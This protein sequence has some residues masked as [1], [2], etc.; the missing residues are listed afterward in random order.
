MKL[1]ISWSGDDSRELASVLRDWIP[2]VIQAAQ[3][4]FSPNDVDKG[5]RWSS[6]IAREL[7]ESD[8]GI[9][10]ITRNNL[11]KPWLM[12]EAGALSK[13]VEKSNL[14]PILFGVDDSDLSGPLTHFQA[15]RFKKSEIRAL[16]EVINDKCGEAKLAD[17]VLNDVFD[18][19]WPRLEDKIK[20]TLENVDNNENGNS[21]ENVRDDRDLIEEILSL[22][23][24]ISETKGQIISNDIH[25]RAVFEI[26]NVYVSLLNRMIN[27]G[28]L[29]GSEDE[30][31]GIRSAISHLLGGYNSSDDDI[32]VLSSKL[33]SFDYSKMEETVLQKSFD[34]E[35]PF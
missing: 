17:A 6:E 8:V 22:T 13:S 30:V 12:F 4:Y 9:V 7:D 27:T 16:I 31:I 5:T 32:N 21:S 26:G 14:C 20:S 24:R 23:R 3:P 10:C 15:T 25:P 2:S 11:E 33:K 1:F 18:M 34:E 35:I 28:S 29:Y 19:W